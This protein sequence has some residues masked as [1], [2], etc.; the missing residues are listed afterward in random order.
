ME[1]RLQG[2]M[3]LFAAMSLGVGAMIG[4]GIFV[5][6]G[7]AA[8][9]AGPA[10]VVSYLLAGLL[11]LPTALTLSELATAFPTAGGPFQYVW[12]TFGPVFGFTT[13]WCLWT[14]I[15][16]TTAFYSIGFA[17]YVAY[18]L[19]LPQQPAAMGLVVLL[20][21]IAALGSKESAYLQNLVVLA[22]L[23]ILGL[24]VFRCISHVDHTLHTPFIP[25]GWEPV[26]D[27]TSVIFV[28]YLGFEF[29]ATTAEEI[30]NPQVNLPIATIGSVLLVVIIYCLV[31]YTATGIMSHVDLGQTSTPIADTAY[32]VMGKSGGLLIAI[33]GLLATM[34]SANG[35]IIAGTRLCFAMSRNRVLPSWLSFVNPNTLVPARAA[36]AT[37]CV[38]CLALWKGE[39]Q[40]LAGAAGILHLLP[41]I[42]VNLA[43]VKLRFDRQYRPLF[44]IPGGI[45]LPSLG[46]C[47][48]AFLLAQS[49]ARDLVLALLIILS[50]LLT[51]TIMNL[52]PHLSTFR[53]KR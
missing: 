8:G 47:L 41:F 32:L 7:W 3:G 50:G 28:S 43:L 38:V 18:F 30:K 17:Q 26:F 20:T 42:L 53:L 19:H 25:Y 33:A 14:G 39:I 37:G 10:V 48:F 44:R 12:E 27:I 52:M 6:S 36:I 11:T 40:W 1:Q 31:I 5:L 21:L 51:F 2:N 13:G 45:L 16:L 29:V 23:S 9:T 49:T 24:Y 34:S 46:T 22:L 35:G 15:G 4:A